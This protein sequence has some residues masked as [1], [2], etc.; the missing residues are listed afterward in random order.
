MCTGTV[1]VSTLVGKELINTIDTY[2]HTVMKCYQDNSSHSAPCE[3]VQVE[4]MQLE[5]K[6]QPKN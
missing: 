5:T 2:L 4:S 3:N 6:H 1:L